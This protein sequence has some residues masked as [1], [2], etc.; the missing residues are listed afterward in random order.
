MLKSFKSKTNGNDG[1]E[2]LS[3]KQ[4]ID[5]LEV[6]AK[7]RLGIGAKQMFKVYRKGKLEDIGEVHDLIGLSLL[8]PDDD[9][10]FG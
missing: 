1:M 8:L 3:R 4:I 2:K 10:I 7:R 6:G 5:M 9:P